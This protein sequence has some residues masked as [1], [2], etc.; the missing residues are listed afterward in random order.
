[1]L[2]VLVGMKGEGIEYHTRS[3][4]YCVKSEEDKERDRERGALPVEV[5]ALLA[6]LASNADS[7]RAGGSRG[8]NVNVN[9]IPDLDIQVKHI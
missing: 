7:S 1:M 6:G 2:S 5:A 3:L 9:V 8:R 4:G